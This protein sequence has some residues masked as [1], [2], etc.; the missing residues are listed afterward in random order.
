M[1]T[2]FSIILTAMIIAA[3]AFAG[4]NTQCRTN[5]CSDV[6]SLQKE[7]DAVKCRIAKIDRER[8]ELERTRSHVNR[9]MVYLRNDLAAAESAAG[10]IHKSVKDYECRLDAIDRKIHELTRRESE[11]MRR[12][13]PSRRGYGHYHKTSTCSTSGRST[14][15]I[16]KIR[17][18]IAELSKQ[19][20]CVERDLDKLQRA[21]KSATAKVAECRRLYD[22]QCAVLSR[23][24][25][26][27]A[28]HDRDRRTLVARCQ[29]LERSIEVARRDCNEYYARSKR[30][31]RDRS[32]DQDRRTVRWEYPS[33]S[34]K[35]RT[36]ETRRERSHN[37]VTRGI[38]A[39][40]RIVDLIGNH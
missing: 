16:M 9:R 1:D 23:V 37:D 38:Y 18:Q 14:G 17:K 13:A 30:Y 29:T 15:E 19:R 8:G 39:F 12:R 5:G 35:P 25:R 21:C 2:K 36:C 24:E 20:D 27:I 4:H 34:E 33:R 40:A 6:T 26:D 31:E 3:T 7:H 28:C 22:A 32:Y 10:R 11:L